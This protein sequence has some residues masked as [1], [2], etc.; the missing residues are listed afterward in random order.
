LQDYQVVFYPEDSP[1]NYLVELYNG[2]S[3]FPGDPVTV[4]APGVSGIDAALD[5]GG[6]IEG[7][8]IG[9]GGQPV[10]SAGVVALPTSGTYTFGGAATDANG[11]YSIVVPAGTHTVFV[12]PPSDLISEYYDDAP[13]FASADAVQVTAPSTTSNI[14]FQLAESGHITGRVTDSVSSDGIE[15]AT[16]TAYTSDG[17]FV[18][19]TSTNANGD[20]DIDTNLRSGQYKVGF[21]GPDREFDGT[22]G[23]VD[24]FYS[25]KSTLGAANAVSVTAGNVTAGI[26][27]A[28]VP[29][30]QVVTTTTTTTSTT[31]GEPTTT[32]TLGGGGLCGDPVALTA[33][34]A[35]VELPLSVSATDGLFVLRASIGLEACADCICDVNGSGGVS[36][37]DALYVLNLAVG[38][39]LP[40]LCPP[41]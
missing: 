39:P 8:V 12:N 15:N 32:T 18:S 41:C 6:R 1:Q 20:Y 22:P 3:G 10:E 31:T 13:D 19:S 17:T 37:T 28:L 25:N 34:R 27:Q 5:R 4:T 14:D 36:A 35:A 33:G 16:V 24:V 26:D 2:Q 29:C 9:L 21:E 23:Y 11:D 30:D 40:L 7:T 38:Q